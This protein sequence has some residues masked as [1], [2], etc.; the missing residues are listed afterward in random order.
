[1]LATD[2]V[3]RDSGLRNYLRR[4]PPNSVLYMPGLDYGNWH[5][6]S[7][8]DYSGNAINGTIVGATTTKHSSG[9]YG[10]TYDGDDYT[11]CAYSAALEV[12]SV[13]LS[14]WYYADNGASGYIAH[15]PYTTTWSAPPYQ[16]YGC[17][18]AAS[19]FLI[20]QG[21]INGSDV[22][23][24]TA[25]GAHPTA[26]WYHCVFTIT[27]GSQIAYV[28]NAVYGTTTVSGGDITYSGSPRFG[29]GVRN[30]DA[31]G[32]YSEGGVYLLNV[33]SGVI[34]AAERNYRHGVERQIF[35]V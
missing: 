4:V 13:T 35:G 30:P 3:V 17:Y 29:I 11:H 10:L 27:N 32:E 20:F 15:M 22:D 18:Y 1:M 25:G 23:I 33:Q 14:F 16:A 34:S 8:L 7:L 28:N 21:N 9:L 6:A 31:L 19:E 2:M 5:T 12:T 26:N 24:R